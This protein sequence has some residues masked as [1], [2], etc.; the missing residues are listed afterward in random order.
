[1]SL[2]LLKDYSLLTNQWKSIL[3]PVVANVLL[4]GNPVNG[5][6]LNATVA[7][8]IPHGLGRMPL[9]WFLTDL[10]SQAIVWRSAAFTTTLITL[11]ASADTT[12]SLWVF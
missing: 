7:K 5:I 4:Q 3:D 8:Q 1:M 11:E 6:T 10:L 2:P 9:G 12:V